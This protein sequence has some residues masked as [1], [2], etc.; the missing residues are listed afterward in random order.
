MIRSEAMSFP[1]GYQ[2][3]ANTTTQN[4]IA[5]AMGAGVVPADYTTSAHYQYHK[6][7]GANVRCA[8]ELLGM[9]SPLVDTVYPSHAQLSALGIQ[10]VEAFVTEAMLEEA[11]STAK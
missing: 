10:S 2:G 4:A 7:M 11:E 8:P 6:M 3:Q 1:N 9:E 5:T